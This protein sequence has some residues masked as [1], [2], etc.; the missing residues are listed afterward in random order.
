MDKRGSMEF[1]VLGI[2]AVIAVVGMVLLFSGA[3]GKGVYG[4]EMRQGESD[5]RPYYEEPGRYTSPVPESEGGTYY[6]HRP[7]WDR[8]LYDRNI[9]PDPQYPV[10]NDPA[11]VGGRTDCVPSPTRD[12][13]WCCPLGGQAGA[14]ATGVY[15]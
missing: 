2:V 10:W 5:I 1:V 4:G 7:G 6:K 8:G 13:Y 3:T 9:C 12:T 14:I 15:E 11:K